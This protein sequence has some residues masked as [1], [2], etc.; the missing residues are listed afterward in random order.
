MITL[1][2]EPCSSVLIPY[3]DMEGDPRLSEVDLLVLDGHRLPL[4]LQLREQGQRHPTALIVIRC[5]WDGGKT[6]NA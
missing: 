4:T 2:P 1:N 3:L 6:L 5:G